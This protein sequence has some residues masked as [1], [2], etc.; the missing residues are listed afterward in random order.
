MCILHIWLS[1]TKVK[2]GK[3]LRILLF[4][5]PDE[6]SKSSPKDQAFEIIGLTYLLQ[7]ANKVM[8]VEETA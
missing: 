5:K 7:P 3:K 1:C 6:K 8:V 4:K 2:I